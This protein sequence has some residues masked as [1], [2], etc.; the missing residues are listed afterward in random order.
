MT[1]HTCVVPFRLGRQMGDEWACPKC[2]RLWR[3]ESNRYDSLL[4]YGDYQWFSQIEKETWLTRLF[5]VRL[6]PVAS[7]R[8]PEGWDAHRLALL[9]EKAYVLGIDHAVILSIYDR[10]PSADLPYHGAAHG[11]TVALRSAEAAERAG[12]PPENIRPLLL[13]GLFHD[14]GYVPGYDEDDNIDRA[15][16]FATSVLGGED[17]EIETLIRSTSFPHLAPPSSLA[18]IIQD[19]DLLQGIEPDGERFLVGLKEERG[20]PADEHFPRDRDLNTRDARNRLQEHRYPR[21]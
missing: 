19:A 7:E 11:V 16:R 10:N 18:A 9:L 15:V 6:K 13:A 2:G 14:A 17:K 1:E 3:I 12:I 21:P 5:G 8:D 20:H 4:P